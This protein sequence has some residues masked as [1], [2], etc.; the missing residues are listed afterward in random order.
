MEHVHLCVLSVILSL[1]TY[2]NIASGFIFVLLAFPLLRFIFP[3]T[4]QFKWKKMLKKEYRGMAAPPRPRRFR[5]PWHCDG[6]LHLPDASVHFHSDNGQNFW[7][8]GAGRRFFCQF[9]HL[10][11]HIESGKLRLS[12]QK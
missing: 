9:L 6:R 1:F 7:Q 4:G 3:K 11:H 12:S 5:F 2:Y 8:P 10:F